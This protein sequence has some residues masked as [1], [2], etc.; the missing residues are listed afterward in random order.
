MK[1]LF[2]FLLIMIVSVSVVLAH[3]GG[4]DSNGGHWDRKAGTYHYHRTPAAPSTT[5]TIAPSVQSVE[6]TVY[7]TKTGEKYHQAGC[8]YLSSSMIPIALSA[9]KTRGYT[10][11]SVCNPPR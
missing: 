9:A 2:S 6:A 4:L 3:P 7:I 5:T 8:R 10:P 11:C 1:K